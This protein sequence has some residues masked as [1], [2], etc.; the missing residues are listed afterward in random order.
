[1]K[2]FR[3]VASFREFRR[4]LGSASVGFA[5]TMGNL[6]AGHESLF[7]RAR[8]ENEIAIA[9]IYVNPK[10]FGP[11]EDFAAYPRTLEA[12]LAKAER[13][14]IDVV[15]VPSDVVMYPPSFSIA[16]SEDQLTRTLCGAFRPGHFNGVLLVVA[17][18][19]N[20]VQPDR[21]YFGLK[22]VQQFR[23]IQKLVADLDFPLQV[24]G[25]Q[26]IREASGLALSSRNGYLTPE[27]KVDAAC[28]S[29]GLRRAFTMFHQAKTAEQPIAGEQLLA[30]LKA[31]ISL[32]PSLKL[33]YA[34]LVRFADF[35]PIRSD[36][37][38]TVVL[39]V[40]AFADTTRLIDNVVLGSFSPAEPWITH[41]I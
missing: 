24:V 18:L 5:P 10:Q 35:T 8:A 22:D 33:Q 29:K 40:A 21:A 25:C 7:I 28:L 4:S 15:F 37:A 27:L 11:A 26:T 17:K 39:A 2:I 1:M 31:E 30:A 38:E 23:L 34:E 12:D 16:M 3:D 6:H 9:S 14:G 36:V 20:L 13:A 19:F 41:S 32:A